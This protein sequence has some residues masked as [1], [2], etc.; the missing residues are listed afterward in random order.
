MTKFE[1]YIGVKDPFLFRLLITFA[2]IEIGF[3]LWFFIF[4]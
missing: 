3:V 1:K 4:K 2:L